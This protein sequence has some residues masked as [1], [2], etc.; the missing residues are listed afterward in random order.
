MLYN[1]E[2]GT[3]F[4]SKE[5]IFETYDININDPIYKRIHNKSYRENKDISLNDLS[6]IKLLHYNYDDKIVVGELII[7]KIIINEIKEVF[8]KLFYNK[9]Q[10][11]RMKLIDDFWIFN[12]PIKSDRNSILNNNTSSF[13]YRNIENKNKLSKH[14]YGLA[15]DINP[16]DNPYIKKDNNGIYDYS[17]L[18]IYEINTLINR[19]EKA[20]YNKHIIV[21]DDFICKLFNSVGFM[22][23]GNWPLKSDNNP[24][25]F[26]HFE[27]K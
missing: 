5:F 12:D 24:Y 23:G 7:N 10:I 20:K 4:N 16:L 2:S 21:K 11:N 9:Y 14:S 17:K 13:C 25:D 19:E 27:L 15:I 1:I 22:W 26:Q 18:T 8:E 3:I 6:Y